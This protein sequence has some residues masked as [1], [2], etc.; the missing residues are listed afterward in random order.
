[1]HIHTNTHTQIQMYTHLNTLAHTHIIKQQINVFCQNKVNFRLKI[2]EYEENISNC[3]K[4]QTW[5][6]SATGAR[7]PKKKFQFLCPRFARLHKN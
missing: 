2:I 6:L 3:N 1:M 4:A 5:V 7:H